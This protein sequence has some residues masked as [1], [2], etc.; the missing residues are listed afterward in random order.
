MQNL[1]A[2]VRAS[3]LV[4]QFAAGSGT[5]LRRTDEGVRDHASDAG[6]TVVSCHHNFVTS[7][8]HYGENVLITPQGDRSC[9]GRRHGHYSREHG[10]AVVHR[11]W[12]RQSGALHE[13]QPWSRSCHVAY[14][15]Q[16]AL[17]G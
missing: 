9:M 11:A 10:G 7:E 12:Q 1:V 2:A 4:P 17:H 3:R 6:H 5:S 14:R 13:L 15:N 16:A 8:H